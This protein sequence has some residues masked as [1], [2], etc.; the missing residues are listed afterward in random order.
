MGF[1]LYSMPVTKSSLTNSIQTLSVKVRKQP[2]F[3]CRCIKML[4]KAIQNLT[5]DF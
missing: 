4:K 2:G 1:N 3:K 5:S